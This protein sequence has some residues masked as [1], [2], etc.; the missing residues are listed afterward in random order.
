MGNRSIALLESNGLGFTVCG[1][2][3]GFKVLGLGF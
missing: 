3:L 2:D 1:E